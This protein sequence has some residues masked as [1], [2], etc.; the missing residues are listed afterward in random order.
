MI[1]RTHLNLEPLEGR[2]L[3]SGLAYSLTTDQSAYQVG[4][5]IVMTFQET[6]V[7]IH[8]ITVAYGP[9]IDGF[10]VSQ[11]GAEVWRSNS[12]VNPMFLLA[13]NLQPGQSLTLTTTWD[14]IPDG[15]TA[16]V[17]GTYVIANELAPQA[18]TATVTISSS[19]PP[20]TPPKSDPPSDPPAPD[21]G[22]VSS[23]PV[24]LSVTT[25]H[26]TYRKGHPVRMSVSLRNT[27]QDPVNLASSANAGGFTVFEG[28][29]AIWHS[30]RIARRRLDA[31]RSVKLTAVWNGRAD[32]AGV[33]IAPGTYTIEADRGR[34]FGLDDVSGRRVTTATSA[35]RAA[36]SSLRLAACMAGLA[37]VPG[38]RA[39]RP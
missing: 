25:N 4:Q 6:N 28:S 38:P 33:T 27:S 34:R 1:R 17:A 11:D 15:G 36:S 2:S 22:P 31:G 35:I 30:A 16:P 14:G 39:A 19:T 12:G 5:P 10:L 3:L 21:P 29:T 18:A 26:P 32:R 37:G 13:D 7:S 23:A 9:S 8:A 24:T 20:S